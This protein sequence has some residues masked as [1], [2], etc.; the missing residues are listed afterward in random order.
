MD[1]PLREPERRAEGSLFSLERFQK[2]FPSGKLHPIA[3]EAVPPLVMQK[4]EQRSAY[5]M[6]TEHYRP[7]NFEKVFT[8]DHEDGGVTYVALQTKDYG[9][10]AGIERLMYL[11]D[12]D[13]THAPFGFGEV[14]LNVSS[15][16]EY[17]THKPFVGTTQTDPAMRKHGFGTRRLLLMNAFTRAAYDLPLYS[18]TLV[19]DDAKRVW[20]KLL[21]QGVAEKFVEAGGLERYRFR[22]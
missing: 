9:G 12:G 10:E 22:T 19:S 20:K 14:R 8:V 15:S 21:D 13:A 3:I 17:F 2:Y 1:I 4:L 18:D 6:R 11:V 16:K 7:G 5:L